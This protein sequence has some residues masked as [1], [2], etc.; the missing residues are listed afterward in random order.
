MKPE[1]LAIWD[2]QTRAQEHFEAVE[3][4]LLAY[5]NSRLGKLSGEFDPDG[6]FVMRSIAF[7]LPDF[8]LYTIVGELLHDLRSSLDHLAWILVV[9]N[10]G[11]PTQDTRFPILKVAPAA[12]KKGINP[13]PHVAGGASTDALAIIDAAQPYKWGPRFAEHPL[14]VLHELWNI[15]K[16]RHIV[17]KGTAVESFVIP[18]GTPRFTFTLQPESV[19][20]DGAIFVLV[21]DDPT[22]DVDIR[23][24]LQVFVQEPRYGV[25]TPLRRTLEHIRFTVFHI[26]KDAEDHCFKTSASVD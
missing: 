1:L 8:R 5:Y 15:D 17:L 2:R 3:G 7:G 20:V 21:P 22:V 11:D 26:A 24:T 19:S 18:A 4:L 9:E 12:N 14:W 6:D 16:H 25:A 10:G 23:T 13:P